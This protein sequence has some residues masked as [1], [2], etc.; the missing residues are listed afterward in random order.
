M[1]FATLF[2]PKSSI[3]LG[4]KSFVLGRYKGCKAA[5]KK[6]SQKGAE[7]KIIILTCITEPLYF[8]CYY[9]VARGLTPGEVSVV[10]RVSQLATVSR[11]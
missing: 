8:H 6:I 11:P 5:F 2:S 1:S 7:F 10:T 3:T 9:L 4:P